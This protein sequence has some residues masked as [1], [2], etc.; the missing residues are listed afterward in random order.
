MRKRL[1]WPA[2]DL[3]ALAVGLVLVF[4]LVY[5]VLGAFRSASEFAQYPPRLLRVDSGQIELTGMLDGS[6][7]GF[8]CHLV[9]F[10]PARFIIADAKDVIQMPADG[11]PFPVRVCCKKH[12][13]SRLGLFS[14]FA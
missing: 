14:D 6:L 7:D 3:M 1:Y 8:F 5:A 4:P 12:M 9:E 2:L 13:R 11:F 10:N